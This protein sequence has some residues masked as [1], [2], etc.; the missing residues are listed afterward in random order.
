MARGPSQW[1][2]MGLKPDRGVIAA[3]VGLTVVWLIFA[4]GGVVVQQLYAEHL[5]LTPRLGLGREPWQ[6]LTSGF[7]HL[8]GSDLVWSL[9]GLLFFGNPIEQ[10]L[11]ERAFWKVFVGGAVAAAIGAAAVGRLLSPDGVVLVTLG[12]TTALLM[13]FGAAWRGQP[14]MAYGVAQMRATSLAWVFLGITVLMVLFSGLPWR[15]MLV[16]LGAVGAAAAAGWFLT[17]RG[18]GFG[19]M[20]G[21][22]DRVRLWR[23]KRRYRVLSGGRSA[24]DDKRYLN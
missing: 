21:S 1:Q 5:A 4:L 6:L 12:S 11:G 23:L 14:V 7:V 22:L 10:Q 2:L 3:M 24:H 18:G 19:N 15:A 20:R 13:A 17:A 16:E 8:R 9:V